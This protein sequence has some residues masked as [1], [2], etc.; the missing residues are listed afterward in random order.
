MILN[1]VINSRSLMFFHI[2]SYWIYLLRKAAR[3]IDEPELATQ[4]LSRIR[5]IDEHNMEEGYLIG[6]EI[7]HNYAVSGKLGFSPE[8]LKMIIGESNPKYCK[9]L[10][11]HIYAW[12]V[13]LSYRTYAECMIKGRELTGFDKKLN[14]SGSTSAHSTYFDKLITLITHRLEAMDSLPVGFIDVGCG[15][16]SFLKRLKASLDIPDTKFLFIGVDIDPRSY[17]I[18]KGNNLGD[19]VYIQGDVTRPNEINEKLQRMGLPSLNNYFHLRSFVDHNFRPCENEKGENREHEYL[20]FRENDLIG[21]NVIERVYL[22]HFK[23]WKPYITKYGI[24]LIELHR[25]KEP[26]M[27]STPSIAYEIF[28]LISGQYLLTNEKYN[29]LISLAAWNTYMSITLP[30]PEQKNISIGVYY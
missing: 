14:L 11:D 27:Y 1:P 30:D 19:I 7:C 28:H 25:I 4:I 20:Y 2:N 15:D 3:H 17:N 22:D 9:Y 6:E 23:K 12:A 29:D 21:E 16:G 26:C 5:E 13:P 10:T 18:A 8:K 24:G